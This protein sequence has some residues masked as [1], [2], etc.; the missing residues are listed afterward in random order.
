MSITKTTL[1]YIILLLRIAKVSPFDSAYRLEIERDNKQCRY[2]WQ[3]VN[4]VSLHHGSHDYYA[5]IA[6][7][8]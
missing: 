8:K 3:M 1:A 4:S 5:V 2:Q 7:Y 6:M